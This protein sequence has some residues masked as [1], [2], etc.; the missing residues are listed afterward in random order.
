LTVNLVPKLNAGRHVLTVLEWLLSL[1]SL[2]LPQRFLS[3]ERLLW[4]YRGKR[5]NSYWSG[6]VA[7]TS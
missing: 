1:Q 3:L 5:S 4:E 7:W 6:W 2:L